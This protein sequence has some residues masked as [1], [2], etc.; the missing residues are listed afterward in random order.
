MLY[1]ADDGIDG[2][3]YQIASYYQTRPERDGVHL[4]GLTGVNDVRFGTA[5]EG[6]LANDYLSVLRPQDPARHRLARRPDRRD[7]HDQGP[8]A[9]D[10]RRRD[11]GR[12]KCLN[13]RRCSSLESELTRIDSIDTV[14]KMG[15]QFILTGLAD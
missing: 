1:N 13:W 11:P 14:A 15:D 5:G 9:E 7:R 2:D 12:G 4:C 10:R 8:S 3:G 6:I